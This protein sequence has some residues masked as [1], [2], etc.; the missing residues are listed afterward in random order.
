MNPRLKVSLILPCFN[1]AD[2]LLEL[3]KRVEASA[4]NW[5]VDWEA[6]CIDDGSS[7]NTWEM[8]KEKSQKDLRWRAIK[9]SRNFGQQVA[10]AAGVAQANGDA[11]VLLDSD[12]QDP[13][14][15]I[16]ELIEKWKSGFQVVYGVHR[17]RQGESSFKRITSKAFY[18]LLNRLSE[19]D[20]PLDSSALRLLDRK[21][22]DALN[23][24]PERDRF[25]RGLVS[26]VGFKQ[27]PVY[28]DRE[29]RAAGDTKYSIF[30]LF[31]VALSGLVSFSS[32]PL[33][34]ASGMGLLFFGLSILGICW[35]LF[36]KYVLQNTPDGWTLLLI[37]VCFFSGFQMLS[38]G[39]L[40]EYLGKI[41]DE[42]KRR[43]LY[44]IEEDS[45]CSD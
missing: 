19:V 26:W 36:S 12:L 39:I 21:V 37:A 25:T 6:I 20:I 27:T 14:E 15:V 28:F 31:E 11:A 24:M 33:R 38:F 7:D 3:F 44:V 4:E 2:V 1:E 8:L 10:I 45:N 30:K 40:G 9:L 16:G 17:D 43:P 35:A 5:D 32:V 34:F 22:I 29:P 42:S 41:F 13:P 23:K 18:R